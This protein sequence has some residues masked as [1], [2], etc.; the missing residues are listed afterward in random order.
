MKSPRNPSTLLVHDGELADLHTLLEELGTPFAARLGAL[1][2]EDHRACWDLIIGTPQRLLALPFQA[3]GALQQ[4]IAICDQDSRTLRDSL[5]RAGIDLM[6]R[7]PVH[8]AALRALLLHA[9]YRGPEKRRLPRTNIGAPVRYRTGWR[10]HP[11]ILAD[12]S[13]GGCRLL[14]QQPAQ[15]DKTITLLLPADLAG[16]RGLALRARVLRT[17]S[18]TGQPPGTTVLFAKFDETGAKTLERLKAILAAHASG[19]ARIDRAT[20]AQAAASAPERSA[21]ERPHQAAPARPR[22]PTPTRPT[23]AASEPHPNSPRDRRSAMRHTIDPLVV[24]LRNEAARVLVGRDISVGGMQV[25]PNQ[26]LAVGQTLRIA[27]HVNGMEA[28]LVVTSQ[29]HRDDGRDGLALRFVELP[30][31]TAEDLTQALEELPVLAPSG[32]DR[33]SGVVVSEILT[34]E[35]G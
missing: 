27:I 34:V 21:V 4:R 8:P 9:L 17:D 32:D 29:V 7:R 25:E 26:R 3:P 5:H 22:R 30:R 12:L 24:R 2:A 15:R 1:E 31:E 19:P 13:L 11:A 33:E 35:N 20:A 18:A 28:P 16:G 14:T 10:Q 23:P 6:I